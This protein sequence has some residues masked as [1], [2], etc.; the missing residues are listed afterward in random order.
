ELTL[1]KTKGMALNLSLPILASQTEA[2]ETQLKANQSPEIEQLQMLINRLQ[3]NIHQSHR[4]LDDIQKNNA[5]P[6]QIL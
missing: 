3:V 6:Q 1:H 4:L 5:D 2:L